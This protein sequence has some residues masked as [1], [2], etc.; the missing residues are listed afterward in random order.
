MAAL[1]QWGGPMPDGG[2]MAMGDGT[3]RTFPYSTVLTNLL[4]A[5]DNTPVDLTP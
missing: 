1:N 2:L 3:V 4:Q 5:E